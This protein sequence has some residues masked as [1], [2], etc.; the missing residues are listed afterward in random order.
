MQ[1]CCRILSFLLADFGFEDGDEILHVRF[2]QAGI[3]RCA[4]VEV[5]LFAGSRHA[6]QSRNRH[7]FPTLEIKDIAG[8]DVGE[9]VFLQEGVDDGGEH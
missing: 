2:V 5:K 3:H 9:E 1:E 6:R 7:Q 4:Q 8:E